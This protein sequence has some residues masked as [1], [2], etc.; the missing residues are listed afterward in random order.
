VRS[1]LDLTVCVAVLATL[2]CFAQPTPTEI[3]AMPPRDEVQKALDKVGNDPNLAPERAV[4]MLRWAEQEPR[5]GDE[6]WWL[7]WLEAVVV[8]LQGLFNWLAESGR[9]VVWAIGAFLAGVLLFY[10]VRLVRGRGMPNVPQRFTAPSH[11]RDLDIRPESL[12]DDVGAAALALWQRGEQRAALALLYRGLLSRLVHVHAVPI[13]ASSTEGEC[14]AL[15]RPRLKTPGAEFAA[16]LIATWA[17]A[18][19]GGAAPATDAV[20]TLCAEFGPALDGGAGAAA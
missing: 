13:R 4:N 12:P 16:R 8:W 9:Y 10:L 19:Y 20:Q 2:P 6:P 1:R 14:L 15:A 5:S 3:G 11:V 18:V 7:Q 17:A